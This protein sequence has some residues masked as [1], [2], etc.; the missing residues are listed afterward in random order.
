MAVPY[1]SDVIIALNALCQLNIDRFS[2]QSFELTIEN[3]A[4][5]I[6]NVSVYAPD[7]YYGV[8]QCIVAN[9]THGKAIRYARTVYVRTND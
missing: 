7:Q 6:L 8:G 1:E 2:L 3:Q 5:M 4:K 9:S